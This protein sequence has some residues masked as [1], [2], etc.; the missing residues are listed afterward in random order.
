M[1]KGSPNG[2]LRY[3]FMAAPNNKRRSD[4]MPHLRRVILPRTALLLAAAIVSMLGNLAS[5]DEEIALCS[6]AQWKQATATADQVGVG[7][8]GLTLHCAP[9]GHS[10]QIFD[11]GAQLIVSAASAPR[12][13]LI[14]LADLK[15]RFAKL[16]VF[17][18]SALD[19]NERVSALQLRS[20]HRGLELPD[21]TARYLL[22][23]SRRDMASLYEVLDRLDREALRAK[24]RLTIPFVR[25]VLEGESG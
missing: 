25:G 18:L 22:K 16:P 8:Q 13:C 15:S 20:K 12:E 23:R 11:A 6:E 7:G 10:N 9:Q 19:E 21:D 2:K 3:E 17:Q 4:F 5:A 24:R 14:E 1:A